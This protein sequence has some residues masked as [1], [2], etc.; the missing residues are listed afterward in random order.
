MQA[1]ANALQDEIGPLPTVLKPEYKHRENGPTMKAIGDLRWFGN[2]DVRVVE[3]PIPDITQEHD[4]IVQVTG[5][6]ICSSN[7]HLLH[8]EIMDLQKGDILGHEFM[9]KV[10]RI[11]PPV[12]NLRIA[13]GECIYCK[14]KLSSMCNRTKNSYPYKCTFA[15]FFGYSHFTSGLPGGR[16]EYIRCFDVIPT[17]DHWIEDT[18]VKPGDMVGV[19]LKEASRVIAIDGDPERL[20]FARENSGAQV[21]N[22]NNEQRC[23]KEIIGT[24][25]FHSPKTLMHKVQKALMLKMDVPETLNAAIASV[26]KMGRTAVIAVYSGFTDQ[27]NIMEKNIRLIGNGQAPVHR[28]WKYILNNYIILGKFDPTFM[29]T[30][31]GPLDDMATLYIAF[32]NHKNGVEKVFVQT[33]FSSPLMKVIPSLTRVDS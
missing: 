6:T 10:A 11:G 17:S 30:H 13:C 7:L 5:T 24:C 32:D 23:S 20:R 1:T 27:F 9:G 4:V 28:C 21:I 25:S 26:R 33:K 14:E 8:G 2:N 12:K 19:W 3:V 22:F 15:G 29:I 31:R 16:A 18:G